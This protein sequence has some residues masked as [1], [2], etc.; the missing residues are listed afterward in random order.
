MYIYFHQF[1]W[2]NKFY[3]TLITNI[4]IQVFLIK[5]YLNMQIYETLI[6]STDKTDDAAM[7]LLH[8]Y[9]FYFTCRIIS[10]FTTL[11]TEEQSILVHAK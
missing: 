6:N 3:K 11:Q 8:I 7:L 2:Y 4:N 10:P 1:F 5:K 9:F